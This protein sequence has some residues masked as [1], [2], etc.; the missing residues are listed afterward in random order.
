MEKIDRLGWTAG[1]AFRSY[2]VRVGVR[3]NDADV[4]ERLRSHLPPGWKP[5]KSPVV[6]HIYSVFV[7]RRSGPNI[8]GYNLAYRNIGRLVRT[9]DLEQLF[10]AFEADLHLNV[11]ESAQRRVFVHAGVVGWKGKAIL[12]PGRSLSGKT[13]LVTELLKAGAAFYSD[14]YAVLDL[15]G[16]VHPY[17]RPL[18]IRESGSVKQTRRTAEALGATVG[19]R[20]LPVGLV[21]VSNYKDGARWR[22][23]AVSAGLGALALLNNTVSIRREPNKA[24][25]ALTQAVSSAP[26]LT[27]LRGEAT[28]TVDLI[29]SR[30]DR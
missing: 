10:D 19:A 15:Q 17:P 28:E 9:L 30:F 13:T 7:G 1:F 26:I 11:A 23:R 16:R 18:A 29:L 14:E 4:L 8:R 5:A 6:Q 3:V 2:G 12:L 24:L 25:S 20:P 22:P 21:V 27:G